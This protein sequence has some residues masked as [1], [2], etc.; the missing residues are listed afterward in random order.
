MQYRAAQM[1]HPLKK[2]YGKKSLPVTERSKCK[3][4]K[5]SLQTDAGRS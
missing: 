2:I 1:S 3:L 4:H 5:S